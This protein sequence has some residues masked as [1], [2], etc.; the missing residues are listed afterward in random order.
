MLHI[1]AET[2]LVYVKHW[3][4]NGLTLVFGGV[5]S[6][7]DMRLSRTSDLMV[8]KGSTC[9]LTSTMPFLITTSNH[10][11]PLEDPRP[12]KDPRS[13][14]RIQQSNELSDLSGLQ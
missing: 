7:F 6:Q 8:L 1:W 12:S 5:P 4:G 11:R 9:S 13:L 10:P 14:G 2:L 3:T